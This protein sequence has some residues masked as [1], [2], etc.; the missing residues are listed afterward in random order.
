MG[1][2]SQR[3]ERG[4]ELVGRGS[5]QA[6][7]GRERP[8]GLAPWTPGFGGGAGLRGSRA[9][10]AAAK[11]HRR[12]PRVRQEI[13]ESPWLVLLPVCS[14]TKRVTYLGYAPLFGNRGKSPGNCSALL[15][16]RR[17]QHNLGVV[18]A[19]AGTHANPM[20]DLCFLLPW[21]PA[22]A[23]MTLV[24]WQAA[25]GCL[26]GSCSSYPFCTLRPDKIPAPSGS[27]I[28]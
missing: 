1:A 3:E 14:G 9:E 19:K 17:R 18:P 28:S 25:G 27:L 20:R 5:A 15:Y 23:G 12:K 16:I 21:M 13:S 10:P 26:P 24:H 2:V 22:C 7:R 4:C 6:L 8:G 11:A